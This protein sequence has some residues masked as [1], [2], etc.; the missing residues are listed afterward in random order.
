MQ[1]RT[2]WGGFIATF[3]EIK[4]SS[5]SERGQYGKGWSLLEVKKVPLGKCWQTG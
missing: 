1:E 5:V 2:L 3:S 4:I